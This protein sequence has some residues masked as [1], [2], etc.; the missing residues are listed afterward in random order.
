MGYQNPPCTTPVSVRVNDKPLAI[1][2]RLR[3]EQYPYEILLFLSATFLF[4]W[5]I[6][7]HIGRGIL[8]Y[9]PKTS[10]CKLKLLLFRVKLKQS[11]LKLLLYRVKL[12]Q[13]WPKQLL[14]RVKQKQSWLKQLLFR[15]KLKQSWL[16][17]LHSQRG[18]LH[19]L[20]EMKRC[21]VEM[22][23]AHITMLSF[24]LRTIHFRAHI[25]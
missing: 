16:G 5:N 19:F 24:Q 8:Y 17:L 14:F 7:R 22:N 20:S 6:I 18:I 12:K 11:W 3:Q 15:A 1:K 10:Y 9:A 23:Y 2:C 13:S 25:P 4:C 21:H